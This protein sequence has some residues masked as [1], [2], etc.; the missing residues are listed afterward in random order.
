MLGRVDRMVVCELMRV[1]CCAGV[2]RKVKRLTLIGPKVGSAIGHFL[3]API[4]H[5]RRVLIGYLLGSLAPFFIS[6][7]VRWGSHG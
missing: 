3:R 5:F 1:S 7:D 6:V 4:G 2:L